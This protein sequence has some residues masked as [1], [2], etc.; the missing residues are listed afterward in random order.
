[1]AHRTRV[2]QR[3]PLTDNSAASLVDDVWRA[4]GGRLLAALAR[5]LGDLDLA[6]DA[7]QDALGEALDHWTRERPPNPAG[8]LA[9]TAWRKAVD[10]LRR[11]RTGAAKLAVAFAGPPEPAAE[12][13]L[14]LIFACCHP[15]LPMPARVALTLKAV[16]GLTTAEIAAAFLTAEPTTAQ[17]LVRARRTLTEHGVPIAVPDPDELGD[18]LDAV[19]ATLY[20]IFNEGYL[21]SGHRQP[22]RRDLAAQARALCAELTTLMPREPEPAG[23]LALI[24]LHESRASTRFDPWG[25]LVLLPD[26]ER[27]R[28]DQSLIA[29]ATAR[30]DRALAVRRP[31]PYQ[32]Q[33]AI[34]ALHATAPSYADTDWPQIRVLYELLDRLA[35]S[36]VVRLNRAVASWHAV[37][38]APALAEVDALVGELDGYRLLHAIRAE[39]LTA[40]GRTDEAKQA[41]ERA[42]ALAVNPAERELLGRRLDAL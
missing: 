41:T 20:L 31:G 10:R 27:H 4:E 9:T 28:W 25:R 39:L 42:L 37:G 30:L 2:G 36:P 11:D 6:E 18:R 15:A 34:A 22:A 29:T 21:A 8:W 23:L 16:G 26:Q 5:R 7:L 3:E 33:A 14:A 1:M 24:E 35:P 13:R 40:L 17:R 12:D 32:T 19:L 38:P